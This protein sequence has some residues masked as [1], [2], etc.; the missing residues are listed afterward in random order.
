VRDLF[1]IPEDVA[2]LNCAYMAPQLRAVT[3]AGIEGVARKESPWQIGAEDFFAPAENLRSLFAS[4]I[5]GDADGVALTPGVSYG[6]SVAAANL[7]VGRGRSV[8]VVEEQFPSNFYP[9]R[10]SVTRD[11]GEMRTVARPGVGG[12]T[13]AVLDRVDRSTAVVAGPLCHW[14]DGSRL[15]VAAIG[16]AARSVGAALVVDGS[17]G[18]GV[19]PFDVSVVQPDFVVTVGYK[20]LLGPYTSGY[21][22]AAPHR[23]QGTPIEHGWM[24]REKAEDFA[25]LALYRDGYRDG[26]RR[27]D[28]GEFGNFV[29][30]PMLAA[31]IQQVQEWGLE[32]IASGIG[33]LTSRIAE[34]ARRRGFTVPDAETAAPH[35]IGLRMPGGAPDGLA[36]EL[37]D[38]GIFVSVRGD[39]VRISP[40]LYNTDEDVDRLLAAL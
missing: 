12:W 5:G 3:R 35:I 24:T 16:E 21:L 37:G 36:A 17:Q 7:P 11:G 29:A 33:K 13:A 19:V 14:T 1:E 40:H 25:S 30:I 10:E 6:A 32:A 15:D 23:R 39:S 27:Y 31:G 28:M 22:W 4:I 2:Y 18:I 20:W 38:R 26:A 9:W 34:V 8:V